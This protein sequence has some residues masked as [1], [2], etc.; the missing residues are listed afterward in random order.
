LL[1]PPNHIQ[2]D[3]TQQQ[4]GDG[5]QTDYTGNYFGASWVALVRRNPMKL[6]SNCA[7]TP[8]SCLQPIFGGTARTDSQLGTHHPNFGEEEGDLS[9]TFV[10]DSE[11]ITGPVVSFVP[12]H[13]FRQYELFNAL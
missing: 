10:L 7:L 2:F 13:F 3:E 6:K 5:T 4:D 11:Q 9:W 8:P 12:E 1:L